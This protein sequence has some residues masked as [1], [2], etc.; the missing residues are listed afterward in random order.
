MSPDGRV[1]LT[2]SGYSDH[3]SDSSRGTGLHLVEFE[4]WGPTET[5]WRGLVVDPRSL[6]DSAAHLKD[7][8]L[9][10]VETGAAMRKR[11][12]E[13]TELAA[14]ACVEADIQRGVPSRERLDAD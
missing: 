10:T 9:M 3:S 5:V 6:E 7:E 1:V 13:A 11:T 4:P 8:V 12:S 14:S 2:R